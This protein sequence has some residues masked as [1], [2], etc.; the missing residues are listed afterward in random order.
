MKLTLS[1][2]AAATVVFGAMPVF[3]QEAPTAEEIIAQ[4]PSGALVQVGGPAAAERAKLR[5]S[6]SQLE[7]LRA[8]KDKFFADNTMKRAQ[9]KILKHDLKNEMIKESIDKGAVL[10]V[11]AKI[12]AL[13]ADINNARVSQMVDASA[14]FTPEQRKAMHS[15]MLRGGF[16]HKRGGRGGD[17]GGGRR[18]GGHHKF[19]GHKFGGPA[20]PAAPSAPRSASEGSG[21]A[22]FEAPV[23][24]AP[25]VES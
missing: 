2:L 17:C 11:Q 10:A 19:G 14:I 6:D 4:A 1:L 23:M 22:S 20:G 5:L 8:L 15:R 18:G 3:A 21:T 25:Q 7:Q 24:P 12:N 13:Q 9:L 16:H